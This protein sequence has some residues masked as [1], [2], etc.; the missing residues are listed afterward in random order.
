MRKIYKAGGFGKIVYTEGEYFHHMRSP[1]ESYNGWRIGLPPQYYP[2]HATAYYVAVTGGS[3]TEVSCMGYRSTE[4]VVPKNNSYKNEFGSETALFQ[5][6][7]GGSAR[8]IVTWDV[9]GY[10]TE[11]GRNFGTEGSFYNNFEGSKQAKEIVSKLKLK[12]PQLPPG[13]EPGGHGGSHG[14]LGN[15]FVEAILLN[16]RPWID[17][18]TALNMTVPGIIAHQSALK[19]GELLKIPQ[20]SY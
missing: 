11:T 20:Y 4:S 10:S 17:I 5:T 18:V 1:L 13:V 19:N 7:N 2:T 12:K 6:N 14:Y 16:R 3:F 15:D 8:M 9:Q